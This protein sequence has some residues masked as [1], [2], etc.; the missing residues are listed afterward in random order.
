MKAALVLA[1]LLLPSFAQAAIR[2]ARAEI[3]VTDTG[4]PGQ[5][6]LSLDIMDGR[7]VAF[8]LSCGRDGPGI[9]CDLSHRNRK[10]ALSLQPDAALGPEGA[11]SQACQFEGLL[12]TLSV[13]DLVQTRREPVADGYHFRVDARPA[14]GGGSRPCE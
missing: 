4:D 3:V 6:N 1:L 7:Q 14:G 13:S 5:V 12:L 11:L 2:P 9:R 8:R 10:A